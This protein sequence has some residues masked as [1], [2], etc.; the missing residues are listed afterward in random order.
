M[1]QTLVKVYLHIVFSTKERKDTIKPDI[2]SELFAYIGG[3]LR[4]YNSVLVAANGTSNHVHLLVSLTK[5]TSI[6]NLLREIKK[7]SSYWIKAKGTE[8]A[9]FQWQAGYGAFSIGQSQ[10][11]DVK[12]YIANQKEHHASMSFETEYRSILQKYQVDFDEKYFLD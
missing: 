9:T 5:N 2:E 6:S 3:V 7:S 12:N 1:A 4:N 11:D 10:M 8:Y